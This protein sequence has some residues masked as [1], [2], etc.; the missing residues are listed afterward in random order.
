MSLGEPKWIPFAL[1]WSREVQLPAARRTVANAFSYPQPMHRTRWFLSMTRFVHDPEQTLKRRVVNCGKACEEAPI[2]DLEKADVETVT[3]VRK[4]QGLRKMV[5]DLSISTVRKHEEVQHSLESYV[6]EWC[7]AKGLWRTIE[8]GAKACS[9]LQNSG[10][11]EKMG[12]KALDVLERTEKL[13]VCQANQ[14]NVQC[15]KD[16]RRIGKSGKFEY[17]LRGYDVFTKG[18]TWKRC[19][20]KVETI[21]SKIKY[22]IEELQAMIRFCAKPRPMTTDELPYCY[23]TIK[24]KCHDDTNGAEGR[25]CMDD[26]HQCMRRI[27]SWSRV[28]NRAVFRWL[29]E[30]SQ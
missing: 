27:I 5:A 23:Y 14:C 1:K 22:A 28:P 19:T 30:L 13:L 18:G 2:H 7:K 20:E 10:S 17:Q 11:R 8:A 9:E 25:L 29:A 12:C 15:D 3:R 21:V 24:A 16:G 26:Q 6:V 4:H